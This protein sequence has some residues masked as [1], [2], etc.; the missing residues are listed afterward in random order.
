MTYLCMI[1]VCI[2]G[3]HRQLDL[4]IQGR[5]RN[6]MIT[7]D[8]V[9]EKATVPQSLKL[10]IEIKL[11]TRQEVLSLCPSVDA[12]CCFVGLRGGSVARI[13]AGFALNEQFAHMGYN[14]NGL[15]QTDSKLFGLVYN[16][17][18]GSSYSIECVNATSGEKLPGVKGVHQCKGSRI[19]RITNIKDEIIA[20][21][22]LQKV[23][24][25]YSIDC[26]ISRDLSIP[27]LAD[28]DIGVAAVGES[29]VA[30][31]DKVNVYLMN[32]KE[33]KIVWTV[34]D[35]DGPSGVTFYQDGAVIMV[36]DS[37]NKVILIDVSTG[38]SS[39]YCSIV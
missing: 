39:N 3:T 9:S 8:G 28:K 6:L 11:T 35:I 37:K 17:K 30:V 12:Q 33:G 38:K 4:D 22:P 26:K 7:C 29:M 2:S 31:T 32:V 19:L 36:A 15:C 25:A 13:N 21:K 1:Y 18:S 10:L 23:L 27:P 16:L 14:V 34:S 5:Y 20:P 24:C